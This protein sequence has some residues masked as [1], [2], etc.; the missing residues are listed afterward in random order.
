[1]KIKIITRQNRPIATLQFSRS[2][3]SVNAKKYILDELK[4]SENII[5]TPIKIA[6]ELFRI[7]ISVILDDGTE[8]HIN[9]E[10]FSI[11]EDSITEF[12]RCS[13]DTVNL[14]S[15]IQKEYFEKMEQQIFICKVNNKA[16]LV[17]QQI[18]LEDNGLLA[19]YNRDISNEDISKFLSGFE[20]TVKGKRLQQAIRLR[21]SS[22]EE[23]EKILKS[24]YDLYN[25]VVLTAQEKEDDILNEMLAGYHRRNIDDWD[26]GKKITAIKRIAKSNGDKGR[27]YFRF[28]DAALSLNI[29]EAAIVDTSPTSPFFPDGKFK[30]K[31]P[32]RIPSN[33]VQERYGNLL[34]KKAKLNGLPTIWCYSVLNSVANK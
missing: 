15:R 25:K 7:N 29:A 4:L 3:K 26:R 28:F 33:H 8:A 21:N 12:Y 13:S 32:F 34:C 5:E 23:K 20:D 16:P 11:E 6:E 24:A 9:N 17:T 30:I 27:L 18:W 1:M 19:Y 31:M 14:S 22:D 10:F 2:I